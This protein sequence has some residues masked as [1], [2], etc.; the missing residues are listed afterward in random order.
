MAQCWM[1]IASSTTGKVGIG[2]EINY[3]KHLD[4]DGIIIRNADHNIFWYRFP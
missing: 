2:R 1:V 3:G 4:F